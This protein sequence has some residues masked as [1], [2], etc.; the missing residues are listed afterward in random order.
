MVTMSVRWAA[1][2]AVLASGGCAK[3]NPPDS[4]DLYKVNPTRDPDSPSGVYI[5]KDLLDCFAELDRMLHPD[6]KR[7]MREG[8]P[9][10]LAGRHHMGLGMWMRNNWGLW[11]GSRLAKYF[12]ERGQN[13]EDEMSHMILT[14]YW[15]HLHAP[16]MTEAEHLVLIEVDQWFHDESLPGIQ[17]MFMKDPAVRAAL[18]KYGPP[19]KE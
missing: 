13:I 6:L 12:R 4:P 14:G 10:K 16:S 17:G 2:A 9:N 11:N 19:P 18:E 8:T 3:S 7:E 1:L 5:P 15:R